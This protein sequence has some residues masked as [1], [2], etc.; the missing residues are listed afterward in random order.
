M[1]SSE[2]LMPPGP[3]GASAAW[4]PPSLRGRRYGEDRLHLLVRDPRRVLA[5][6]ELSQATASAA[7][8]RARAADA[9]IRYAL[10]IERAREADLPPETIASADLPDA[11]GGEGWYVAIPPKAGRC[12]AVIG[13][14]LPSGFEPLLT[15]RWAATPPDGPCEQTAPWP[16]DASGE[17]WAARQ[18]A[19]ALAERAPAPSSAARYLPPPAE[20]EVAR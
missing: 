10:R 2:R 6:W 13:L 12:R 3:I 14:S 5:I 11:L 1:S 8:G 4:A 16:L 20:K 7:S 15:S 17:A 9:P 19:R 18:W